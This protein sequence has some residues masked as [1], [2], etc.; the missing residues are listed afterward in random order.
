MSTQESITR[1]RLIIQKLRNNPSSF[2]EILEK[3]QFESELHEMNFD[4]SKRTF[5]RDIKEIFNLYEI[6]IKCD[7]SRNVY[8]IYRDSQDEY[9]QRLFEVLDIYQML[10]LNQSLSDFIEFSTRKPT[11]TEHLSGLL[12]AI[13]NRFQLKISYKKFDSQDAEI[14]LIEPYLLKEFKNRWYLNAYDTEKKDFRTYGIDRMQYIQILTTKFQ[15]PQKIN[16]KNLYRKSFGIV[17]AGDAE[18]QEI[19]LRFTKHQG[20][21]IRTLPLHPS[22]EI[23]EE[24]EGEMLVRLSIVPTYDFIFELMS[25]GA[26]LKVLKPKSLADELKTK[27][28]EAAKNYD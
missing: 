2:E 13:Q 7:R 26:N 27:F 4:I 10:N 3:L 19:L 16:P 25:M 24:S 11:G 12:Y 9:S 1:H 18:P 15:F 17:K 14:R 28:Q 22:Q 6:E 8:Y 5:Q 23:L 21:Y 20:E